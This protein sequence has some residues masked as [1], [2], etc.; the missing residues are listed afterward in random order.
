MLDEAE[1][2][3]RPAQ[4]LGVLANGG[5]DGALLELDLLDVE[6]LRH[7]EV[8]E[9]D[10]AVG[11][12]QVVAG[13]RIGIEVLQVV[14]RAEA[15][16]KHD[17]PEAAALLGVELLDLVELQAVDE[18][19]HQHPPAREPG[20]H[21]GDVDERVLAVGAREAA[22][23]L[24]LVLV[25]ELLH[26]PL[27][28]LLGDRLR[29]EPGRQRLRQPD[30]HAGVSQVVLE[31]LGDPRVLDLDRHPAT[32]DQRR[33]VHLADRGRREGVGLE[34]GEVLGDRLAVV[35]DDHLLD[36]GPGHRRGG[37]AQLRELLLVDL[38]VFGGQK[39][40]VDERGELAQL[41]RRA[42][43]LAQDRDH[44]QRRLQVARFEPLLCLLLGARQAG[45]P[46]PCVARRLATERRA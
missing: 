38:G 41:H 17:L 18:L 37:G 28:K 25:V 15:E 31:C 19:G 26:H 5:V 30:Q 12:Q 45:R 14:D 4:R 16:A 44:L 1:V 39:L 22:L 20:D 2:V 21:V 46:G 43:H 34:L 6:L 36:L 29:V 9:G 42:L 11:H 32:V 35:G 10:T 3:E 7:P 13:V 23:V 27:A 33:P 24:G 40:G 8:E